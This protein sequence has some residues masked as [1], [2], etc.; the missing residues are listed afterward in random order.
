MSAG[1]RMFSLVA[2][3]SAGSR[4]FSLVAFF[5]RMFSLVA[6][7]GAGSR[8]FSLVAL[9]QQDVLAGGLLQQSRWWPSSAGCS[10]GKFVLEAT[11]EKVRCHVLVRRY[12]RFSKFV[13]EVGSQL[14]QHS[15]LIR[16]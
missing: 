10:R 13:L 6:F 9:L 15:V 5:S 12:R 14:L 3:F 8:M 16:R 11:Q 1:S 2:F 4:M 7:F